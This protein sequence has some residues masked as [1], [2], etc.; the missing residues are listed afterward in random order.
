MKGF[1]QK[2]E[3][4]TE[5]F[6]YFHFELNSLTE[7]VSGFIL[8]SCQSQYFVI[9]LYFLLFPVKSIDAALPS[10]TVE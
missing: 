10:L 7:M 6:R 4:S 2:Q 3:D 9:F 8:L 1:K 5:F